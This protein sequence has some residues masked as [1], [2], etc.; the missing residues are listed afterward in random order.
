M[1]RQLRIKNFKGWKEALAEVGIDARFLCP[2][3][4]ETKYAEKMGS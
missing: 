3:Y 1:L 4:I 2:E